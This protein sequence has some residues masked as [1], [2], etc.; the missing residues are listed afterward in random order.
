MYIYITYKYPIYIFINLNICMYLNFV[1]R[2]KRRTK[3]SAVV[4]TSDVFNINVN[5]DVSVVCAESWGGNINWIISLGK[6][7]HILELY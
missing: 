5:E 6:R 1:I 3:Q 7:G 2:L 4:L